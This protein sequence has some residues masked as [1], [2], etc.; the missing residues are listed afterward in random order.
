LNQDKLNEAKKL[1]I[2]D[3]EE[4]IAYHV[5]QDQDN[6]R[7]LKVTKR[8][9]LKKLQPVQAKT[10]KPKMKTTTKLSFSKELLSSIVEPTVVETPFNKPAKKQVVVEVQAPA[11]EKTTK[12]AYKRKP[13]TVMRKLVDVYK[14]LSKLF[15]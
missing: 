9:Y 5:I 12:R 13:K 15:K 7:Q 3:L 11:I 6:M 2:N 8:E 4:F 1:G 10:N 14:A